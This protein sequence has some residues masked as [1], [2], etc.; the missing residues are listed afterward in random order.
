MA[1][2]GL[3]VGLTTLDVVHT[4]GTAP[5]PNDK[6]T[7][8]RQEIAAGGPAANAAVTFAAL[9]GDATLI[10][11][12][13]THALAR[14]AADELASRRVTV[15]DATPTAVEAPPVSL[16][17]VVDATG[18]RSVSSTNASGVT[19]A[20]PPGI[21]GLASSVDVVLVDGHH[22]ELAL[23]A[24]DA[25]RRAHVPVLLD[26]GSWKPSLHR[27]L[28]LV[29]AAICSADF[30]AP[31]GLS[32]VDSLLAAGVMSAAVT[33]GSD[34][35]SWATR[36]EHGTLSPPRVPVRDTLAAG[37]AFHGAAAFAMARGDDWRTALEFAMTVAAVRVQHAGPRDWL[38]ALRGG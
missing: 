38:L 15:V 34:P 12:L 20:P 11:A 9:G 33:R 30:E 22:A 21:D 19:A 10:T 1:P 24:A 32:T 5:A 13:G 27:L 16:V 26:G 8:L 18:E 6:V 23:A 31:S 35:I 2:A 17:R 25:A 3:F 4:V 37:D 7:A 14:V 36:A 29:D 28:A